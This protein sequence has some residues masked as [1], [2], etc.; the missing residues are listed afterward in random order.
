MGLVKGSGTFIRLN[1]GTFSSLALGRLRC[2]LRLEDALLA[3]CF[4]FVSCH[5]STSYPIW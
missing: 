4:V 2:E 3:G 5:L 1:E